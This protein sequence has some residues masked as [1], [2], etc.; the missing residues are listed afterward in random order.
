M[1]P[2]ITFEH[3]SRPVL[4][5]PAFLRRMAMSGVVGGSLVVISLLGGMAGY[6]FLLNLSWLDSF[7][8]AAMILSGMGPIANPHTD[9]GKLFAGSYALYS[10]LVVVLASG[11]IFAP[12]FHR[13]I[14]KFHAEQD[15]NSRDAPA[16][17][18]MSAG[19]RGAP[20][21]P[22]VSRRKK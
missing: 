16:D 11:V 15:E 18:N 8:N 17:R 6:H 3:R 21:K 10:G 19:T 22:A 9:A 1:L 4:S 14:H 5:R 12:L 7:V 20:K 2:L 13:I